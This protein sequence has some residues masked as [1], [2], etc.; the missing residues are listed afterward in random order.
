[1]KFHNHFRS[2]PINE[3]SR[4]IFI[5]KSNVIHKRLQV[6]FN[7]NA[8][9]KRSY[10]DVLA[11]KPVDEA[12][13]LPTFTSVKGIGYRFDY[14]YLYYYQVYFNG[15]AR[16]QYPVVLGYGGGLQF[17]MKFFVSFSAF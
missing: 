6:L 7:P 13:R 1:M 11:Q 5:K 9:V 10:S 17:Q 16:A 3:I 8:S 15:V 4:V 2:F 12:A 14:Y